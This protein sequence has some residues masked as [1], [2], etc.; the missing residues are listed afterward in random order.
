MVPSPLTMAL[1]CPGVL[2]ATTFRDVVS[3]SPS[4]PTTLM[5]TAV[6]SEVVAVSSI[7][8]GASSTGATVTVTVAVAELVPSETV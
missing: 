3:T 6:S 4:L 8:T 2:T 5:M 1:P 7:A